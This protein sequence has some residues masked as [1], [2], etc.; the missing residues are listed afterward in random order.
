VHI[1]RS[2]KWTVNCDCALGVLIAV[3]YRDVVVASGHSRV[4]SDLELKQVH[5]A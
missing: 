4:F 5:V 1:N 3:D 2:L